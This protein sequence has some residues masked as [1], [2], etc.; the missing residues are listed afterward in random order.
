MIKDTPNKGH[1][2][3]YLRIKDKLNVPKT[4]AVIHI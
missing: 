2:R 4:T 3:N 1:N